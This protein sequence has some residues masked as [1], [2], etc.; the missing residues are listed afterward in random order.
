[1]PKQG[2]IVDGWVVPEDLSRTFAQGRQNRVDILVGTNRDEGSFAAGFGPPMTAQR[3]QEGA[4]QRWGEQAQA[5]L[6]AYPAATD[7]EAATNNTRLFSDNMAWI[8]RHF[9]D[10]QR[11]IGKRAYVYYFAH[12]PPY[13]AGARNLGACHT[14]ELPYVFDNLGVLRLYP[15][16]S[17]PELAMASA[18]DARVAAITSGYWINFAKTGDPNGKGL[19]KWPVFKDVAQGPVLHLGEKPVVGDALGPDRVKLYQ[20]MYDKQMATR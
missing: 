18:T 17:S 2:M 6:K 20:A 13:A 1:L 19:P 11:A 16:S 15:D 5:G 3:W 14:C 9:A 4:G 12:E 7:A 10:R 8:T